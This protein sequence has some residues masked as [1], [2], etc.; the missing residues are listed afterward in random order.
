MLRDIDLRILMIILPLFAAAC[1]GE[2]PPKT[3]PAPPAVDEARAAASALGG[4]L[5]GRLLE[6]ISDG[7]PIS[8]IGVCQHEAPEIAR[9]VSTDAGLSVG[10]TALK[11]RNPANAPDAFERETLERFA[12]ALDEGADPADLERAS[13]VDGPNGPTLRY[14]KPI[15]TA[16]P[17]TLCHGTDISEDVR[18]A[19]LARYPKDAAIGFAE[20]DLRGAFTVTKELGE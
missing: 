20:G 1:G 17:C 15:M 2:D 8:A 13:I 9:A 19:I 10:R 18:A 7:G 3:A 11:I 6:A 4:R 14:M 16:A 5:K 12:D